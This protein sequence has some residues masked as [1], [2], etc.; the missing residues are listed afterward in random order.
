MKL[1][2]ALN[3]FD[4]SELL[5]NCLRQVRKHS[6]YIVAVCQDISNFGNEDNEG[7]IECLR[8]K[9][10]GL[11][12]EVISYEPIMELLGAA[13]EINKRNIGIEACKKAKCTH[14]LNLDCDE[15]YMPT[16]QIAM[17]VIE[18]NDYDSTAVHLQSYFKKPE[19]ALEP[20]DDFCV[21][22]I[23]KLYPQSKCGRY[24]YP[25]LTDPTRIPSFFHRFYLFRPSE[26]VMH[27]F[28]GLR[29]NYRRKLEN[30]SAKINWENRIDELVKQHEDFKIGDPI[31]FHP[32]QTIKEV[33]NYFN[34]KGF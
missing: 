27:H 28:S 3:V 34:I 20:L 7:S 13:N 18:N 29:K 32:N 19:F 14:Y 12:D 5:E 33:P 8:L 6:H 11:I 30:S 24:D 15:F 23:Q 2:I 22:F 16:I 1:G 9:F 17:K 25:I 31:P 10:S 21:P 4:G 26:I